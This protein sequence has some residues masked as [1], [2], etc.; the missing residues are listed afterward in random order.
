MSAICGFRFTPDDLLFFRDGRPST[1]GDDHDL[2]SLFPPSPATL[3]G[4]LRARRL[5]DQEVAVG[6]LSEATWH[7]L[8]GPELEAE[9][10]RWGGFGSMRLRGP[11]LVRNETEV[12]LPAPA[13]VAMTLK[14]TRGESPQIAELFRLRLEEATTAPR[15]SHSLG[16]WRPFSLRNGAWHDASDHAPT[17]A[18][19][20][21]WVTGAGLASWAAG[22]LPAADDLVHRSDLWQSE[23]R[24]GVGLAEGGRLA[25]EHL[26]FTF[27]YVRLARNVELGFDLSGSALKPEL[28]LRLGGEGRTGQLRPGPTFP[29]APT[30]PATAG[31]VLVASLTPML[32][33]AGAFPPG[34]A[35]KQLAGC[36][37]GLPASLTGALVRGWQPLGGWD[38]VR[39]RAKPLR[40]AIPP[41]SVFALDFSSSGAAASLWGTTHSDFAEEGSSQQG[42]GLVACGAFPT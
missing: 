40:R 31:R 37:G 12:L 28:G 9:L 36:F 41:G 26:L 11:W 42:F 24:V 5:F 32:S 13:D 3:Y 10:G 30:M 4:A 2:E 19:G 17:S 15:W 25:Q 14:A 22:G 18:S 1:Q 27:G 35:P 7:G 29:G 23:P 20:E 16:A 38:L 6:K 21:W 33:G 34:F 39:R 8:L